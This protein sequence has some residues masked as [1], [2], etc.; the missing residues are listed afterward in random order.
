MRRKVV[1]L[2]SAM[3]AMVQRADASWASP[4]GSTIAFHSKGRTLPFRTTPWLRLTTTIDSP[5]KE[6]HSDPGG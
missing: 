5:G 3:A 6:L 1:A 4:M 2:S